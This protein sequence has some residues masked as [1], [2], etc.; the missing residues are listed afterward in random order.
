MHPDN[1]QEC[2]HDKL[3]DGGRAGYFAMEKNRSGQSRGNHLH[4]FVKCGD[5]LNHDYELG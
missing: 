1:Q 2:A 5:G 4:M 3:E